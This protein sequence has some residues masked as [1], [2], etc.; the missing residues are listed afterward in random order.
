MNRDRKIQNFQ[1]KIKRLEA[2]LV[3]PF[4]TPL[5][6]DEAFENI[7]YCKWSIERLTSEI[8]VEVYI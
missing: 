4:S 2:N 5:E 3:C 1:D 7:E 8:K 6:R